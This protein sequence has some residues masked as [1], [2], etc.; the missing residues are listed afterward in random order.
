M[1]Q[2]RVQRKLPGREKSGDVG[3]KNR[4]IVRKTFIDKLPDILGNEKG[5]HPEILRDVAIGV[6]GIALRHELDNACIG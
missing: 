1:N 4:G 5:V 3:Q 2:R 6:R